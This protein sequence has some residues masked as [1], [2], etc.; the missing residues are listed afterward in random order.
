MGTWL[1][2]IGRNA[3]VQWVV[4]AL[5]TALVALAIAACSASGPTLGAAEQGAPSGTSSPRP[6][7]SSDAGT[8]APAAAPQAP[9]NGSA[10]ASDALE[11]AERVAIAAQQRMIELDR[12]FIALVKAGESA[13]LRRKAVEVNEAY[14]NMASATD[15]YRAALRAALG[16]QA[17]PKLLSPYK[18][19]ARGLRVAAQGVD[20]YRSALE[21][22]DKA[23]AKRGLRKMARGEALMKA[24][25]VQL[26]AATGGASGSSRIF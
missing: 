12:E 3:R 26:D 10:S 17:T 7:P 24:A 6:E 18:K 25:G 4:G 2:P 23:L 14:L 22:G 11:Q 16:E 19:Q 1:R 8:N 15:D 21:T 5:A 13:Q 9:G 20:D